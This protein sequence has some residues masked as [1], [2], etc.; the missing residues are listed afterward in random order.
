MRVQQVLAPSGAVSWTVIGSDLRPVEPVERYLAW[1]SSI[2]RSPNTVRAY[3]QDLKAY[4]EFLGARGS[5][6]IG[7]RWSSWASSLA[8]C[9]SRQRT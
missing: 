9:A 5:G 3:A 1:L 2:E 6:G 8:G 7:S 4:W